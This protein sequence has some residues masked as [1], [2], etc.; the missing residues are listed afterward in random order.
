M[1]LVVRWAERDRNYPLR[2]HLHRF[3]L[4]NDCLSTSKTDSKIRNTNWPI[5]K[6][7]NSFCLPTYL[8]VVV[9]LKNQSDWLE[10]SG[11]VISELVDGSGE[12]FPIMIFASCKLHYKKLSYLKKFRLVIKQCQANQTFGFQLLNLSEE[13]LDCIISLGTIH[14]RCW[15]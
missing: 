6:L 4:K 1:K 12:Q 8:F 5:R 9:F 15:L 14:N 13:S 2:L 10:N 11:F 7:Y 3:L